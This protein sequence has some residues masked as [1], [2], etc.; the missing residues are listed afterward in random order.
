MCRVSVGISQRRHVPQSYSTKY[1]FAA[2]LRGT[3][4]KIPHRQ[5]PDVVGDLEQKAEGEGGQAALQRYRAGLH[6]ALQQRLAR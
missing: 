4:C 1:I 5:E 2:V 6:P 3:V